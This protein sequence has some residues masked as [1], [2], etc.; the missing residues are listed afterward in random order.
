MASEKERGDEVQV[1]D[2]ESRLKEIVSKSG[3]VT[4]VYGG[5]EILV[6]NP[7]TFRWHDVLILLTDLLDDV[8]V[9]KKDRHLVILSK[10]PAV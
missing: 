2:H 1:L 5:F 10:P 9:T 3:T 7:S 6:L 4:S 8:W